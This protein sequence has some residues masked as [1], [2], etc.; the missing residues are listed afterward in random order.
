MKIRVKVENQLFEVEIADLN[1]RPIVATVDGQ[2]FEI[3]PE[4]EMAVP[5]AAAP[6]AAR[7]AV[8]AAARSAPQPAPTPR[9]SR[10]TSGEEAAPAQQAGK[11]I[12]APIPGVIQSVG[13]RAGDVVA[14]GQELCVLEAMKMKNLIRAPRAGQIVEIC[15]AAGDHVKH[16]DLLFQYAE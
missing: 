15:V 11:A 8:P 3:W 7:P 1:G 6:A 5:V 14:V 12:Y 16:N 13:V 10:R 4:E 2:P 9:R